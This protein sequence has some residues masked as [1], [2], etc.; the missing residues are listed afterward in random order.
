VGIRL[1]VP[2]RPGFGMS[3]FQPDRTL[4]DWP[5]DVTALAD[6]LGID[7]FG[8]VGLS[9]GGPYAIS[10][11]YKIPQRLT[12]AAISASPAPY[13]AFGEPTEVPTLAE[14]EAYAADMANKIQ[15]HPD[16]FYEEMLAASPESDRE[17]L[18][19]PAV[20]NWLLT[21]F[22]ETFRGGTV[23]LV[24]ELMLIHARPWGFP[25]E[26]ITA[27]VQIWHGDADTNVPFAAGQFLAEQIPHCQLHIVSEK[28]HFVPGLLEEIFK[29]FVG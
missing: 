6:Y 8:V 16:E 7:K 14:A 4:L 9:G 13:N 18:A 2:E 3:N 25:L 26:A 5:D 23:G 24:H 11:A 22:R 15:N 20:R 29:T 10:C 17:S 12:H 1:I 28:G 19:S 27:N 21:T